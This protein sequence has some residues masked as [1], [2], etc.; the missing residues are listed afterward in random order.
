MPRMCS[1]RPHLLSRDMRQPSFA[2]S[3]LL[4]FC[5]GPFSGAGGPRAVRLPVEQAQ[6]RAVLL[7][8]P[9]LECRWRL[10]IP[11][12]VLADPSRLLV[13]HH[14]VPLRWR[15]L[16][17][18]GVQGTSS[19]DDKTPVLLQVRLE[20]MARGLALEMTIKNRSQE[21]LPHVVAHVCLSHDHGKN[22]PLQ[23]RDPEHRRTYLVTRRGLRCLAEFGVGQRSHYRVEGEKPIGLFSNPQRGEY[24]FWGG[25]LAPAV[26]TEPWIASTD[27]TGQWTVAIFWDRA[28][29]L[30]HN[31]DRPNRCIHSDPAFGTL[32]PG[33]SVTRRGMI[34]LL[35]GTPQEALE[36]F[37]RWKSA[38]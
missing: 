2:V 11:E 28:A 13:D 26:A 12:R 5:A 4:A 32:A 24:R 25:G 10:R 19:P 31:G 9:E 15:R 35:R 34:L 27:A 21:P 20:P 1:R 29:E 6:Q 16:A 7:V 17:G 23:F 36:L 18:R 33:Q 3:V 8:A 22:Q 38:R 14:G 30:F 37:R